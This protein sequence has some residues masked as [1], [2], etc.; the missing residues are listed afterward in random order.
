[1]LLK[2]LVSEV[3]QGG[4]HTSVKDTSSFSPLSTVVIQELIR[5]KTS[6][7]TG[8]SC[9]VRAESVSYMSTTYLFPL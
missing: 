9:R 5:T 8:V 2:D 7:D 4:L 1:M 6:D 3:N